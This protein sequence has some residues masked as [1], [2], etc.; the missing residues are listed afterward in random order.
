ME[1]VKSGKNGYVYKIECIS[2]CVAKGCYY[3]GISTN[4]K[5]TI[6]FHQEQFKRKNH[7]NFELHYWERKPEIRFRFIILE[8]LND[9]VEKLE[10]IKN[11]YIEADKEHCFNSRKE[12]QNK[13]RVSFKKRK[14]IETYKKTCRRMK[15][16]RRISTDQFI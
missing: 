15:N 8:K 10:A 2:D 12:K 3:I 4:I 14:N 7:S 5:K 11:M 6:K 13:K 1:K 16:L 9:D